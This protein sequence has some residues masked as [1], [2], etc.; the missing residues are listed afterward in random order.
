MPEMPFMPQQASTVAG[1]VDALYWFLMAI[2]A[3]FGLLIAGVVVYFFIRY[4]RRSDDERPPHIEGSLL[5]E[6][7]WTLVP[8]GIVMIVFFWSAQVFF[9]VNRTPPGAMEI[10]VVGKRWMWKVQHLSGQREIN[11][12]HVPVGVP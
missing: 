12:L 10:Y 2:S 1:S 5:L 3:F 7:T 6:L 4:R 9:E 11:E 8:L